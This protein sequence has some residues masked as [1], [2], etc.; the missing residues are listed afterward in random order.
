[1]IFRTRLLGSN[2]MRTVGLIALIL[3]SLSR[4]FLH[5]SPILGA[6]LIDATI[7]LFYGVSITCLL[8]SLRLTGRQCSGDEA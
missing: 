5:P 8:L 3:A 6:N 1:M 2:P 7:G 4:W